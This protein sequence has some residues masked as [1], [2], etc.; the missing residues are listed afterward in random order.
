MTIKISRDTSKD[1]PYD[2]AD[3]LKFAFIFKLILE[4]PKLEYL[5]C[6]LKVWCAFV[7]DAI[8]IWVLDWAVHG[9]IYKQNISLRKLL[10]R[11]Y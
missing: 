5:N 4:Y 8:I 7:D 6:H 1:I 9:N 11:G 3:G 10:C 2:A